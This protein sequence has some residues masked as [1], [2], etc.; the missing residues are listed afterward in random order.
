MLR[1]LTNSI[2]MK[3]LVVI[4]PLLLFSV[5]IRTA[6]TILDS[7]DRMYELVESSA[8]AMATNQARSLDLWLHNIGQQ[9]ALISETDVIRTMDWERQ[10]SYILRLRERSEVFEDV[11]I[12]NLEGEYQ[13][14]EG[15]TG[16]IA[17]RNYFH[18]A[19]SGNLAF[20]RTSIVSRITD[21]VVFTAAAPIFGE[22][23]AIVGVI[24]VTVPMRHVESLIDDARIGQTG[25]PYIID[26]EGLAIVHPDSNMVLQE[27]LSQ[28]ESLSLR[29][30][31]AQM[32]AGET[33]FTQYEFQGTNR[34][35][36]YAPI[37]ATGWSLVVT[38]DEAEIVEPIIQMRQTSI[39][40]G[41]LSI[42]ILCLVLFWT[43]TKLTRPIKQ[44]AQK[45]E[46][47]AQGDFTVEIDQHGQDEVGMLS[48]SFINLRDELQTLLHGIATVTGT[49]NGASQQLSAATQETRASIEQVTATANEFA[50]SSQSMAENAM[51]MAESAYKVSE[52]AI[53]GSK[54]LEGAVKQTSDLEQRVHEL[55]ILVDG[56]GRRSKDIEGIVTTITGIADQTN[57]LALNAA[58][59][60]AR[61]GEHGLGFA[62]VADEVSNLANQSAV[63]AGRVRSLI[64][65]V[66]SETDIAVKEMTKGAAQAGQSTKAVT[67]SGE[68]LQDILQAIS[69]IATETQQVADGVQQ[70]GSGSEQMV[71]ANQEQ[72]A[73]MEEI[74]GSAQSLTR[75]AQELQSMIERFKV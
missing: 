44:L 2:R 28:N 59:E 22:S 49:V 60:A 46:V 43:V 5:G 65:E 41:L 56:L 42:V 72:S 73:S 55:A 53:E 20:S 74:A 45:A 32:L 19:R 67:E 17:N 63:A 40:L 7:Q 70:I 25:Y 33:G 26:E 36:A 18:Q 71:A 12:V 35:A 8:L 10:Q 4:V 3:L 68:L 30:A 51:S 50:V 66:Q 48:T 38:V 13:T 47:I 57:L 14:A 24:A 16:S 75:I 31:V 21:E 34:Y 6:M 11:L 15:V 64:S 58:I 69:G 54:V 39:V 9:V 61:A 52:M 29:T 27:N 37:S 23:D 62:V 1:L